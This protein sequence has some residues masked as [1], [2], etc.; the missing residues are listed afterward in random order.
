[1]CYH[2]GMARALMVALA[3]VAV[4]TR[5][6]DNDPSRWTATD[7]VLQLT[8]TALI[9]MDWNQTR[10]CLS[11]PTCQELNPILGRRPSQGAVATY[12]IGSA[13]ACAGISYALP[14]PWRNMWQTLTIGVEGHAV[15]RHLR[16]GL[17]IGF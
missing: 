11:S 13:L 1:M 15:Y 16:V 4:P 5:A 8:T 3:L 17:S 6:D 2:A 7:T 9:V 12:A 10:H 14:R